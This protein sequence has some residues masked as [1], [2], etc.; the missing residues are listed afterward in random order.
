MVDHPE[1]IPTAQTVKIA[2][3]GMETM[4]ADI[5]WLSAIQYIGSNAIG[6]D[7]KEYLGVM[8]NLITDISPHFTYPYQIGM[9]LIPDINTRYERMTSEQEKFHIEEAINLGKKGIK[10]NC[11]STKIEKI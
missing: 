10:N 1:F 6:A 7:Y 4:V 2:S 11:V 3:V 5:Y 9:L 8:L